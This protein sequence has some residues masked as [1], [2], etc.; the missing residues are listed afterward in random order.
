MVKAIDRKIWRDLGR[1]KGQVAAI[2]AVMSCGLAIFIAGMTC[3]GSLNRARSAYYAESRF[4]HVFASVKTA[5]SSL[6][7]RIREIDGVT[8]VQEGIAEPVTVTVKDFA[9]PVTGE[10][11]SLPGT[12]QA[13]GLNRVTVRQGRW[14]IRGRGREILVSEPFF[15]AHKLALGDRI[16]VVLNGR[17]EE[18][19]I[20]GTGLSPDF[21]IEMP[22]GGFLPDSLRFGVFWMPQ[23]DLEAAFNME[24]AFNQLALSLGRGTNQEEVIRQLDDLLEPYGGLGAY[25]RENQ[26]SDRFIADE[27][28]QLRVMS[29][30][31]PAIFLSIAAYLLNVSLSRLMNLQRPQIA[32]LKSFGYSTWDVGWHYVK[33]AS[34]L[35][36]LGSIG[37]AL[38]GGW[39]GRVMTGMYQRFY[40]FPLSLYHADP[41][42]FAFAVGLMA[43]LALAGV[44]GAVRSA[45]SIPPAVAMQPEPPAVYRKS[46]LDRVPLFRGASPSLRMLIRELER[47]PRRVFLG[48]FGIAFASSGLIMGNFGKDS[49]YYIIDVQFGL[50]QRYDAAVTFHRP[51]PLRV[52][53]DFQAIDGVESVE[54]VRAVPVKFW[55]GPRSKQTMV[56]G[57]ADPNRFVR[58]KQLLDVD[59][60]LVEPPG[61]G[62]LI[63]VALASALRAEVGDVL[64]L[65]ILERNRPRREVAVTGIVE[66]FEGLSAYMSLSSINRLLREGPSVT[67]AFL[68]MDPAR[69]KAVYKELRESPQV[70]GVSLKRA[71]MRSFLDTIGENLLRMRLFNIIFATTIAVGVIYNSMRVVLSERSRELATMRVIGFRH[72]EV[73]TILQGHLAVLVLT[74]IPLGLGLGTLFCLA[75]ARALTTDLYRVPFV[76]NRETFGVAILV[77]LAASLVC[78]LFLD[79]GIRRLDLIAVLKARD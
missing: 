8:K 23:E 71:S 18:L 54:P 75:I 27:L 4:A 68:R 33:M 1:M 31:P 17:E 46:I 34:L 53:H 60:K 28:K 36:L 43:L 39:M 19:T 15:E 41:A 58:L 69:E 6:T 11:I 72:G 9:E 40:R 51:A 52:V 13:M 66:D 67:V 25:G 44:A 22:P 21:I 73:S 5:P 20:T 70:A 26:I 49:I 63:S 77:V 45:V 47:R 7:G 42:V 16:K 55:H 50:S 10:I 29:F 12:M 62:L 37:G 64:V 32:V 24:G 57:V 74:A 3:Q 61:E 78:A 2:A 59:R 56:Q 65:E 14:P 30:F 38:L 79:R 48:I 35:I 76:L